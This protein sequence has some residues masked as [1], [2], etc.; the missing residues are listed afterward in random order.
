MLISLSNS[1]DHYQK[2][3]AELKALFVEV[4]WQFRSGQ[5][6][7]SKSTI[8]KIVHE[9]AV[10]ETRIRTIRIAERLGFT[11][12]FVQTKYKERQTA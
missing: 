1:L 12:Q 8:N 6:D 4:L 2:Q 11:K 5:M 9:I 7:L 10:H 3:L